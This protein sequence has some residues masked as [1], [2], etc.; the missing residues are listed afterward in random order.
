MFLIPA[1]IHSIFTSKHNHNVAEVQRAIEFTAAE[2]RLR[3]RI[4]DNYQCDFLVDGAGIVV[5]HVYIA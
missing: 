3:P 2:M 1:E 5:T 4:H